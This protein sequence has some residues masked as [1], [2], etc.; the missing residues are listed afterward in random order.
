MT[1]NIDD[2]SSWGNLPAELQALLSDVQH[3]AFPYRE[4][5]DSWRCTQQYLENGNFF[6]AKNELEKMQVRQDNLRPGLTPELQQLI[7]AVQAGEVGYPER[8]RSWQS[9]LEYLENGNFFMAKNELEK[10][11][12]RQDNLRQ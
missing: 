6:M 12:Y 7:Q 3:K 1:I 5:A 10:I 2:A 11:Q 8:S 4:R 9:L